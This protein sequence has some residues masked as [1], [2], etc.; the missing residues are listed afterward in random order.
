MIVRA[1]AW[2]TNSATAGQAISSSTSAGW[3]LGWGHLSL[4][5]GA[6]GLA[7]HAAVHPDP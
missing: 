7:Q 2:G 3:L 6:G 1:D 5:Q 4:G